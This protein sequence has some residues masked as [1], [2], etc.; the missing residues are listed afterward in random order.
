METLEC[1]WVNYYRLL[2][3]GLNGRTTSIGEQMHHSMKS[4]FDKVLARMSPEK[5]ADNMMNKAQRKGK[6][7]A[8]KNAQKDAKTATNN[9]SKTCNDLTKWCEEQFQEQLE[10]SANHRV[11][12]ISNDVFNVYQPDVCDGKS[13]IFYVCNL[14]RI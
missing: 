8:R 13:C 4:G 12:Q 1:L 5:S 9:I 10:L 2:I 14:V 3:A 7:Q 11:V 6:N